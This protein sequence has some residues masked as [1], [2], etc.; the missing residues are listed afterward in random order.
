[1]FRLC[2]AQKTDLVDLAFTLLTLYFRLSIFIKKLARI[3]EISIRINSIVYHKKSSLCLSTKLTNITDRVSS[4]VC[5]ITG[6]VELATVMLVTKLVMLVT[7]SGV[8][9]QVI[10]VTKS[11]LIKSNM[12][13]KY[14]S[15]KTVQKAFK[16]GA[17]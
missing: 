16:V 6:M 13:H 9:C 10:L 4:P 3:F 12:T 11:V 1:M 7:V 5:P 2:F 15:A 14:D 17:W 8:G